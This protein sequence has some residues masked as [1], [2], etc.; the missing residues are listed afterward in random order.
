[1]ALA[2][3]LRPEASNL[4][5]TCEVG[6]RGDGGAHVAGSGQY[7]QSAHRAAGS[8]LP[9]QSDRVRGVLSA[10][11]DFGALRIKEVAMSLNSPHRSINALMQYL[12]RKRLV[13]KVG[14][15][16]DAPY[17][18]TETGRAILAEMIPATR[19]VVS[20]LPDPLDVISKPGSAAWQAAGVEIRPR[21]KSRRSRPSPS[22]DRC[23]ALVSASKFRRSARRTCARW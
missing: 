15:E 2:V 1:M 17:S 19:S 10:I 20:F 23:P 7:A 22:S 6:R 3:L 16:F 4:P 8:R 12:K 18:L 5:S 21:K 13:A 14:E 11:S 9:V